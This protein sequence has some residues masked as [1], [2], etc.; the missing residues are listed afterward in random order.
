[1][2]VARVTAKPVPDKN[3]KAKQWPGAGRGEGKGRQRLK[4]SLPNSHA[5]A[6]LGAPVWRRASGNTI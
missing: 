6:K 5:A 4:I 3:S 2:V 1:M